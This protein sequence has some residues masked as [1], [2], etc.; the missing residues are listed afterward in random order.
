MKYIKFIL[1]PALIFA[2]SVSS[3][4]TDESLEIWN[5]IDDSTKDY[6]DDLGIDESSFGEI[7][8]IT[9]ARV[10]R[11]IVDIASGKSSELFENIIKILVI[12]LVSSIISSFLNKNNSLDEILNYVTV[13]IV[14]SC[15]M[16]PVGRLLTDAATAIRSSVIFINSYLPVFTGIMIASKNPGLAFTYNSFTLFLSSI[17]SF[18]S[19]KIFV[20]IISA[21]F[22]LCLITSFSKE[23]I[24]VKIINILRKFIIVILS[25]FSTVYTGLLT[26]QSILVSSS[27]S[28][29][30]KGVRF[31]SGTFIP[32]VGS[33]VGD[34][35]TS[36]FSSFLIM[37]NSVGIFIIIVIVLINLPI[38]IELLIYYFLFSICSLVASVLGSD[39]ISN[40]FDS[41]VSTLSMLNI[42]LFFITFVLVIST[43]I[44]IVMG[45]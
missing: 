16:E 45:K 29:V 5:G 41:I 7:F 20:P 10:F 8:D 43:G 6:L 31:I 35:L 30:L 9:P 12:I 36:V 11:L 23:N 15:I 19:D 22:S 42:I 3:H 28:L 14:L 17:I 26:T 2:F 24:R 13:V 33:G 32:F 21:M 4:A 25:L 38:I 40:V 1:I 44:I 39:N 27:D 37:K 34:A 18:I